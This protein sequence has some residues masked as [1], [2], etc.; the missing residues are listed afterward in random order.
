MKGKIAKKDSR[1]RKFKRERGQER[2]GGK[3]SNQNAGFVGLKIELDVFE[4]I[5]PELKVK[6]GQLDGKV[7]IMEE[8]LAE[9]SGDTTHT[10][11][12]DAHR[13]VLIGALE[14]LQE[15]VQKRENDLIETRFDKERVLDH[16]L[17]RHRV[18]ESPLQVSDR[19]L[20]NV[21]SLVTTEGLEGRENREP[22]PLPFFHRSRVLFLCDRGRR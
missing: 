11:L 16:S 10:G 3:G 2:R 17:R 18:K 1:E 21:W 4:D 8:D 14:G 6:V 9:K 12:I 13:R 22:I 20:S 5:H 15:I 19:L 7:E